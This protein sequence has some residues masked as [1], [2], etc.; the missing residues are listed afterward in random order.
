AILGSARF[1]GRRPRCPTTS[2]FRRWAI[3]LSENRLARRMSRV[4]SCGRPSSTACVFHGST[5]SEEHTSEL[6]APC[7][8]VC[9]PLLEKKNRTSRE[10]QARS[11]PA[12]AGARARCGGACAADTLRARP[13][14]GAREWPLP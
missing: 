13:R 5:R 9:R 4:V 6:Q 11:F 12:G 2:A 10:C 7:K 14:R 8:L 1:T 3:H